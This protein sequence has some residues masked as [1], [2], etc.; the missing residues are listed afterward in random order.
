MLSIAQPYRA[1]MRRLSKLVATNLP[2][3]RQRTDRDLEIAFEQA[4]AQ[5]FSACVAY[6]FERIEQDGSRV[7]VCFANGRTERAD[8]L[9]GCDRFQSSVRAR[10]GVL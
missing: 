4:T 1:V 8:L 2:F 5:V 7:H 9:V 3:S 6:V 10:R